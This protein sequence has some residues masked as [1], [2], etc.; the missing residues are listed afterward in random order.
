MIPT[1]SRATRFEEPK[2]G[3]PENVNSKS[4]SERVNIDTYKR[5]LKN[6]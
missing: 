1:A 5:D 2:R 4:A 6:E 3:R